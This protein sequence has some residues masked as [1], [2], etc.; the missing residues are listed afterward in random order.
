M[1]MQFKIGVIALVGA[2]VL[3]VALV[4]RGTNEP[5]DDS[6]FDAAKLKDGSSWTQV[7]AEPYHMAPAVSAACAAN[8]SLDSK[9]TINPHDGTSITVYVNKIGRAAMFAKDVRSFPEGSVIVKEKFMSQD[10][11]HKPVLYTLMKKRERGYNPEV[12]NWEF[13]VVGPDGK[14]V[15][16]T[17][18]LENCESC[19]KG[20]SDSDFVYRPYVKFQ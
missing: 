8:L 19:H 5:A 7:N 4:V 12:G 2:I 6:R 14:Q 13:S 11:D 16:E 18:R 10:P 3:T 1:A 9:K 17:G 20:Q 15:Q